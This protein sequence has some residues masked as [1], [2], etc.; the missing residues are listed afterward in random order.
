MSVTYVLSATA[1][2]TNGSAVVQFQGAAQTLTQNAQVV[3]SA[4]PGTTYLVAATVVNSNSVTL[5][6]NYSGP[7]QSGQSVTVT[8]RQTILLSLTQPNGP[9]TNWFVLGAYWLA[10]PSNLL[11]PLSQFTSAVAS[12]YVVAQSETQLFL[13]GIL[14]EQ[15]VAFQLPPGASQAN[16]D[17]A[18]QAQW[19]AL[20]AAVPG[21]GAFPTAHMNGRYWDGSTVTPGP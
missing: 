13:Q 19:T 11:K 17:A 6:T 9:G 1:S 18:M 2:L 15:V 14:T 20:Q 8:A 12:T 10:A 7:T 3:F 21:P 16:V 4:Q 5:S